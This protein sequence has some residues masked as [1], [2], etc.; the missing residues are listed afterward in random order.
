KI[1]GWGNYYRNVVSK[2]A[3]SKADH[4]IFLALYDWAVRR[5]PNKG[6]RWIRRK[7]FRREG[8]RNWTF[9]ARLQNRYLDL[10]LLASIPIIRH[11]KIRSSATP[12]D[13]R[14]RDYFAER[15]KK[16][17]IKDKVRTGLPCF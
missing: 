7:Y 12:Y 9:S 16:R 15:A 14:F 4:Q 10:A 11:H 5:H 1:R 3:F 6:R 13:P 2:R 17:W 8:P